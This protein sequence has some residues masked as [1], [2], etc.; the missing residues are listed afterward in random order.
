MGSSKRELYLSVKG[1][2][3]ESSIH[4]K[5]ECCCYQECTQLAPYYSL[6]L[7]ITV[8]EIL[9]CAGFILRLGAECV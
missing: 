4:N 7:S 8:G 6:T 2:L 5:L 9:V 1:A 3:V